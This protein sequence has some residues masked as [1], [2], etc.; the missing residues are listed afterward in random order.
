MY[1]KLMKKFEEQLAN[2]TNTL[3]EKAE[4]EAYKLENLEILFGYVKEEWRTFDKLITEMFLYEV[5]TKD[6]YNKV[7]KDGYKKYKEYF[8]ICTNILI[9]K[10]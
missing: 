3:K 2:Y 10:Q 4:N 7:Y 8:D 9:E 6:E 5:L 1:D